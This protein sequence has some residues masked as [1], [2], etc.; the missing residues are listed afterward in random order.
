MTTLI[1]IQHCHRKQSSYSIIQLFQFISL[2]FL[3]RLKTINIH[4][5]VL[6]FMA[7]RI[8]IIGWFLCSWFN[9]IG[10]TDFI[11]FLAI[12]TECRRIFRNGIKIHHRYWVEK[13]ADF[14]TTL[15]FFY[16]LLSFKR[17][18]IFTSIFLIRMRDRHTFNCKKLKVSYSIFLL[19]QNS[20][21]KV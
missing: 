1:A 16:C 11:S 5:Y 9:A 20:T 21:T 7:L 13:L 12:A 15:L 14:R 3:L 10:T 18:P 2:F 6:R 4:R 8:W 19:S 17:L